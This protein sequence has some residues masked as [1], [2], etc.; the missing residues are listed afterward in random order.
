MRDPGV[1]PD[2]VEGGATLDV[3]HP[4]AVVRAAQRG[5]W[6]ELFQELRGIPYTPRPLASN[7]H[8]YWNVVKN[9]ADVFSHNTPRVHKILLRANPYPK[10][11]QSVDVPLSDG[12]TLKGWLGSQREPTPGILF[13]PGTF[14]SKDD[15]GRKYKA[16]KMWREWGARVLAIDMRGFGESHETWG[17]GGGIEKRDIL[18][19]AQLL[20]ED[21]ATSVTVIGESLGGAASLL[22][23]AEPEAPDL[24]SG[25]VIAWSAYSD[26]ATQVRYIVTNPGRRHP[27]YVPHNFFRFMLWSRTNR[28]HS[29]FDT[30]LAERADEL[31]VTLDELYETG[32][33]MNRGAHIRVPTLA[34]HARDDPIVPIEQSGFFA[35]AT[36]DNPNVDVVVHETGNHCFFDEADFEW[37]WK[38]SQRFVDGV[39]SRLGGAVVPGVG[40]AAIEGDEALAG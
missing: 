7:P 13:V 25:G 18:D 14:H 8:Y 37:Y 4:D 3:V 1:G 28:E 21:G 33:A 26:L 34:V 5:P 38:T 23:A 27:F 39:A 40:S 22:A 15:T 2:A 19:A 16:I 17:A 20:M 32:S 24:L 11:F 30:F 35:D 10:P 36:R 29:R 9:T 12:A 31:G 6:R